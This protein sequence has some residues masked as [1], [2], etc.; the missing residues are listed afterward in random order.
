[1]QI[2]RLNMA[3]LL[4]VLTLINGARDGIRQDHQFRR[5]DQCVSRS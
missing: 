5:R 3:V 2:S 4:T 1:M